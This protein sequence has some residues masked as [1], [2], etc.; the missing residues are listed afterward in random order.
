M[1]KVMLV[2]DGVSV[3][4]TKHKTER[5][6]ERVHPCNV[7]ENAFK[8]LPMPSQHT[9]W[10]H[11]A[12][13]FACKGCDKKFNPKN[14]HNKLVMASITTEKVFATS[15]CGAR[16]TTEKI[17]L[18]LNVWGEEKRKRT[19]LTSSRKRADFL[20]SPRWKSIMLFFN[21]FVCVMSIF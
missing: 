2:L 6:R 5:E 4:G 20:Y 1:R 14:R 17:I 12:H 16:T 15:P 19:V 21:I 11:S 9:I 13:V 8:S 3:G 7:C 18:N 10:Q